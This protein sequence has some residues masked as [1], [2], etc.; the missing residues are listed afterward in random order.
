MYPIDGK[1]SLDN[2]WEESS[3]AGFTFEC[4]YLWKP[5]TAAQIDAIPH[6]THNKANKPFSFRARGSLFCLLN[7]L[8]VDDNRDASVLCISLK[9]CTSSFTLPRFR[10]LELPGVCLPPLVLPVTTW[11]EC[12]WCL[13]VLIAF[14]FFLSMLCWWLF[15]VPA[16]DARGFVW[17]FVVLAEGGGWSSKASTAASYT[18]LKYLVHFPV[19]VLLQYEVGRAP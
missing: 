4:S 16:W 13:F 10:F 7:I 12:A 15:L 18:H 9:D 2:G 11:S 8:S 1:F 14:L 6:I 3:E 5:F 17:C 19:K